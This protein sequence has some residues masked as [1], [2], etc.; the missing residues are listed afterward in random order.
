MELRRLY[1]QAT[2]VGWKFEVEGDRAGV[3]RLAESQIAQSHTDG[4]VANGRAY[5]EGFGLVT[6]AGTCIHAP[7][8]AEL[9]AKLEEFIR[10]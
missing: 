9:F 3:I 7:D 2:L 8:A 5:G 10:K 6:S 4:C 1:P